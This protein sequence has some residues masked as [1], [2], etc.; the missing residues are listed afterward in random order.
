[1]LC[2]LCK[3]NEATVY[4]TKII[5]GNKQEMRICEK[6]AKENEGINI[7]GDVNFITPF[8]FQ[9][10]LSGLMDY[11]SQA[12]S[13]ETKTLEPNCKKCGTTYNEFK[14]TG[15][16]GCSECYKYFNSTLT[17]LIKRVQGSSENVGKIPQKSG[18][19]LMERKRLIQLKDELQKAIATE[20]YEKAAKIRDSIR[21]LQNNEK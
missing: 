19:D 14:K 5:N 11:I 20:E 18:K 16:F 17:P 8:S 10:I 1:M 6:C 12:Q 3:Q 15:V 21:E 9:N 13:T 2:E 7:T 4:I